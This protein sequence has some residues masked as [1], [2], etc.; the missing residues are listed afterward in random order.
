MY[1][2]AAEKGLLTTHGSAAARAYRARLASCLASVLFAALL[3]LTACGSG[4]GSSAS[5]SSAQASTSGQSSTAASTTA[6]TTSTSVSSASSTSS[7]NEVDR[8]LNSLTTEQ[9][10]A[11]LFITT[12]E[13]V[14]NA[15]VVVTEAGDATRNAIA[16][17]P[18]GGFLYPEQNLEGPDQTK[19]LLSNM[20][21]YSK[22]SCGLP[23]FMGIDEEGGTVTRI[24][25]TGKF[26]IENPGDMADIGATGDTGKAYT[27]AKDTGTYLKE[28]G[29]NVDFAPV[30]DIVTDPAND[31]MA[32]RSFGSD[33]NA[34]AAMVTAQVKG[35]TDAGIYC[36]AKHF[37]G[38]GGSTGGDSHENGISTN[39]SLA[40]LKAENLVPFQAAI[41]A[42]VPFIMVGHLSCPEVTGTNEPASLSKEIMTDLLRK[43]MGYKGIIITDSLTM[44]AVT[45][46][47]NQGE[48]CV[49][50]FNSGAD[51]LLLASGFNESYN[52][53]LDAVKSGQISEERL[54]ESVRR[55]IE[56]KLAMK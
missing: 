8:I 31:V 28:L 44:G 39:K 38:I 32:Q 52:A 19:A 29:F 14:V 45:G 20:N 3:A 56:Y 18:V 49:T 54:D 10:V 26:G 5:S 13:D 36:T 42:G 11:Q 33:P 47:H 37:P 24:A 23:L 50:A 43:D 12:P 48:A 4:G 22:E 9:K 30:A 51:V 55:I 6:S 17:Y 40:D 15:G 7:T 16:Q 1:R 46:N 25:G 21:K 27:V 34:V 41:D 53:V 2:P 35:F